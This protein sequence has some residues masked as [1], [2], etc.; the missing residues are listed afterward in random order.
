MGLCF[1]FLFYF[2][3]FFEEPNFDV[4]AVEVKNKIIVDGQAGDDAWKEI[5]EVSFSYRG[6]VNSSVRV[7]VHKDEIYFLFKLEAKVKNDKH[8][9]WKFN[10]E[11]GQFIVGEEREDALV[12]KW[13]FGKSSTK[14]EAYADMWVW[15][16]ARTNDSGYADDMVQY[17]SKKPL[18]YFYKPEGSD[19]YVRNEGDKGDK[20]W[21]NIFDIYRVGLDDKRY[22]PSV[23]SGSRADIQAKARWK[24]GFWYLEMKRKLN[25]GNP[26]DVKFV[27]GGVYNFVLT[28]SVFKGQSA[29]HKDGKDVNLQLT[30]PAKKEE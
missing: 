5:E 4:D 2:F 16:A 12:I 10:F 19:F 11:K 18:K 29:I 9:N 28:D 25:T 7:A 26:D 24:D 20:C 21:K 30:I 3:V 22:E 6:K 23:P 17:I 1:G 13:D 8:K 27:R 15:G 14:A